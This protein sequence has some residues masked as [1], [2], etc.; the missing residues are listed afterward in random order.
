MDNMNNSGTNTGGK[1]DTLR[2]ILMGEQ[3]DQLN[4]EIDSLR[5]QLAVTRTELE[6]KISNSNKLLF[7]T[8][9]AFNS[10]LTEEAARMR[11]YFQQQVER[12]DHEKTQR[13]ELGK[14]LMMVGQ[15]LIETGKLPQ[16][17]K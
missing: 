8:L 15:Q 10:D 11:A 16:E 9:E 1:L 6:D 13:V 5:H 2:N 4:K 12:I 17:K 14:M 7:S 3:V